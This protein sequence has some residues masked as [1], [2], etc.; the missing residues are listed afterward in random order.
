MP[1]YFSNECRSLTTKEI[2]NR[3]RFILHQRFRICSTE[4]D[5]CDERGHPI[6]YVDRAAHL[7]INL[8]LAGGEYL[9]LMA[10]TLLIKHVFENT[11]DHF[12]GLVVVLGSLT[13]GLISFV[14]FTALSPKSHVTIYQDEARKKPLLKILQ[15]QMLF[16]LPTHFIIVKDDREQLLGK[17]NGLCG[18]M[19]WQR[20][21]SD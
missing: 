5:L 6:L 1:D 15:D 12:K 19:W 2:F 11:P 9:L 3:D 14:I 7:P 20:S 8:G 21:L 18:S 10:G 16:L 17:F 13:V 4:Y